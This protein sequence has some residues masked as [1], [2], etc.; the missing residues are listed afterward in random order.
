MEIT[1]DNTEL[2][3]TFKVI[4][5][6]SDHEELHFT[7]R[8][9]GG[10]GLDCFFTLYNS[11]CAPP[12]DLVCQCPKN[13][14]SLYHFVLTAD[15]SV[16]GTWTWSSR[17]GKIRE[18]NIYIAKRDTSTSS[19][20]GSNDATDG[21]ATGPSRSE[22][23]ALTIVAGGSTR[24]PRTVTTEGAGKVETG[25]A[26]YGFITLLSNGVVVLVIVVFVIIII[27]VVRRGKR[28]DLLSQQLPTSLQQQQRQLPTVP[29]NHH[30]HLQ[31]PIA[32]VEARGGR[33][34]RSEG[35][36]IYDRIYDDEDDSAGGV[37]ASVS[38]PNVHTADLP[39]D[40]LHPTPPA[41]GA[42]SVEDQ[43]SS[44]T[45]DYLNQTPSAKEAT[46][47]KVQP[48]SLPDDYLH[49]TGLA[50]EATSVKV[51]PSSLPDDYLHP[52]GL[53]REAT[54]VK[55][56]P[57]SLP[58]DYL[59]PTGLAREAT[60]VEDQPSS[61]TDDLLVVRLQTDDYL[62]PTASAKEAT[63]VKVQPSLQ[64]DDYLHPTPSAKEAT[65]VKVRPS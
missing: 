23:S 24:A 37:R 56:Q 38:A 52:T 14:D 49:P 3:I 44:Q 19:E 39:T 21:E 2:E 13:D 17:S 32:L 30:F 33:H 48:S 63:S 65:S 22:T 15:P 29:R 25:M 34:Y 26:F 20:S 1:Y 6:C 40:Y 60:S 53:A 64:P 61:Q 59:H 41:R 55:V 45:D 10:R 12:D 47:V 8:K 42:T 57:S 11:S 9:D 50:R 27:A 62:H 36:S 4:L 18:E 5:N 43:S 46:S 16:V 31:P 51:Q 7:I 35:S 58:D 28:R 54:S